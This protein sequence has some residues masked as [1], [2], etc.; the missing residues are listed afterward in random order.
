MTKEKLHSQ[1]QKIFDDIRNENPEITDGKMV[2]EFLERADEETAQ[3]FINE[4]ESES[5]RQESN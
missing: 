1:V 5:R 2:Q 3:F 4:I